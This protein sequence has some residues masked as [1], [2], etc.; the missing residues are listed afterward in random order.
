[1]N[2]APVHLPLKTGRAQLVAGQRAAHHPIQRQRLG[3][4]MRHRGRTALR[5]QHG[6]PADVIPGPR[7]SGRPA[8][9]GAIN[10][11]GR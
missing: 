6:Q 8:M 3:Q 2:D 7:W 5:P 9:L 11:T 10:G 1:M 4:A